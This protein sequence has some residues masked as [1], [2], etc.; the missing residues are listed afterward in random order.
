MQ[1]KLCMFSTNLSCMIVFGI[2]FYEMLKHIYNTPY[3]IVSHQLRLQIFLKGFMGSNLLVSALPLCLRCFGR[4]DFDCYDSVVSNSNLGNCAFV[5]S[6]RF[7]F[8]S[9]GFVFEFDQWTLF[10]IRFSENFVFFGC[11]S[12]RQLGSVGQ[13]F[14][15]IYLSWAGLATNTRC[16]FRSLHQRCGQGQ[17]DSVN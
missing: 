8:V 6:C 11:L 4:I 16:P 2:P 7:V 10:G 5:D 14:Y 15:D 12:K 13:S 1:F 3:G 17:D 9:D